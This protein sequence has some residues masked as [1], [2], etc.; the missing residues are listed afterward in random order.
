[1]GRK[2]ARCA[3]AALAVFLPIGNHAQ[4]ED[5]S[6]IRGERSAVS[7]LSRN[8]QFSRS[9]QFA[10]LDFDRAVAQQIDQEAV[11][12][13]LGGMRAVTR[14]ADGVPGRI[15]TVPG[16]S[17]GRGMIADDVNRKIDSL[18]RQLDRIMNPD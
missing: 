11:R 7:A 15:D 6:V 18:D 2:S 1:M 9:T 12:G 16:V 10:Q 8:F 4:A 14:A 3:F 5:F 13:Y 17:I